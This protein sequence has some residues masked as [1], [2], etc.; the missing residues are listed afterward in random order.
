MTILFAQAHTGKQTDHKTLKTKLI[1]QMSQIDEK[2]KIKTATQ[3]TEVYKNT[4]TKVAT[5][6]CTHGSKQ[7]KRHME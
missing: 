5:M 1:L 6:T 2:K 4:Y 3:K 7:K